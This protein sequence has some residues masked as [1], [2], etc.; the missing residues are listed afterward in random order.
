M[1]TVWDR[2]WANVWT[3]VCVLVC[4]RD[5]LGASLLRLI[6]QMDDLYG[7]VYL[8]CGEATSGDLLFPGVAEFFTLLHIPGT[9]FH[10][11][12]PNPQTDL[13]TGSLPVHIHPLP[14]HAYILL[15]THILMHI[16]YKQQTCSSTEDHKHNSSEIK[17]MHTRHT[18]TQ[19][20]THTG[21]HLFYL[22][23]AALYEC[24]MRIFNSIAILP[25]CL[26][27]HPL[28]DG[29]I[30]ALIY[31]TKQ[32]LLFN[33]E[34]GKIRNQIR[35]HLG[36][37][38]YKYQMIIINM[39]RKLCQTLLFYFIAKFYIHRLSLISLSL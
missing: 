28:H 32:R 18:H 3:C 26:D 11:H 12:T 7:G 24:P 9:I 25:F 29:G 14:T 2:C 36:K 33:L 6:V 13:F 35:K 34:R 22:C 27:P 16:R 38:C 5:V 8:F 31:S 17:C 19:I 10:P 30:I 1:A 15:Q 39:P 23:A 21:P 4:V 37:I 20:Y